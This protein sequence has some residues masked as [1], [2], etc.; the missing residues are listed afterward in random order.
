MKV[1]KHTMDL[2]KAECEYVQIDCDFYIREFVAFRNQGGK[3]T[4]W[5]TVF[6]DKAIDDRVK[7]IIALTGAEIPSSAKYVGTD[8]FQHATGEPVV[9]HFFRLA[10]A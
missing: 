2:P 4:T 8:L 7:C 9:L 3:P 6:S 10:L 1:F 5:F